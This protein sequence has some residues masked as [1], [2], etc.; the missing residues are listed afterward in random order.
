M[1]ELPQSPRRKKKKA[2][3]K[4]ESGSGG[5]VPVWAIV[6]GSSLAGV[7]VIAVIVFIAMKPP[8]RAT[9]AQVAG[10]DQAQPAEQAKVVQAQVDGPNAKF[11]VKF[12]MPLKWTS[13][14]S[15][16]DEMFPWATM[17][18]QGQVI[19]FSSNR[20]L[21]GGAETMTTTSKGGPGEMLKMS[22]T[23]R[24]GK[25]QA[26]NTDWVEGEL[27]VHEGKWGP[28]IWSDYEY[29]GVFSKGYGVRCTV[30]GPVLPCTL[31]LEC[32]QSARDKWRPTLLAIAESIH[33]VAL[34]ENGQEERDDFEIG[35]GDKRPN[36]D[37]AEMD[38]DPEDKP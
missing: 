23:L 19:K 9:N 20:S 1:E 11:R 35:P 38:G 26:E 5:K 31:M 6:A 25:L 33:F 16:E 13:E 30:I 2:S 18:G 4:S 34:N 10:G 37:Q 8:A 14:G 27:S 15:I 24:R 12:E 36:A 22:H 28:V 32:P 17:K 3:Q 7:L 29:K 21:V